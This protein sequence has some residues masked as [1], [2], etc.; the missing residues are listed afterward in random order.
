MSSLFR[1]IPGKEIKGFA[2]KRYPMEFYFQFVPGHVVEVVYSKESFRFNGD[3]SVNTIISMPHISNK[4]YETM[5]NLGERR[6]YYPLLRGI[7]DVPV[8]G[9]PVLLCTIGKINYYL[10]PINAITNNPT[11]NPDPSYVGEPVSS[12]NKYNGVPIH[13][14]GRRAKGGASLNFNKEL[15]YSRLEKKWNPDLDY[16]NQVNETTGDIMLE[17]RHGNSIRIGSRSNNPY[18]F[19]SNKRPSTN[20]RESLTDGSLISILSKGSLIQHFGSYTTFANAKYTNKGRLKI[21][22][23]EAEKVFGFILASDTLEEP[24]RN[25]GSI[26]SNVNNNIDTQE[27]IYNYGELENQNQMLFHSDRI[28]LN[29]KRD[30]IYLSSIKD[31]HIGTGRHLTIS[32]N[33]NFIVSS[34]KTFIGNP[35]DREDSME[36]MVLGKTLLELLKETLAVIKSSQGICNGAPI[37]LVDATMGPLSAK[38][39]QI[40]QKIDQILSTKHFIEPNA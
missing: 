27:I 35:T 2:G 20:S 1:T 12:I 32:T 11:W 37:P 19:I 13:P 26:V 30:D 4:G 15:S 17:G 16:G 21:E 36:P 3:K 10:G 9:D 34:E 5:A 28:I 14:I 6:R 29:S 22:E 39:T 38:I 18:V 25:M 24:N 40:E 23:S 31:V 8:K 7:T 33:Q